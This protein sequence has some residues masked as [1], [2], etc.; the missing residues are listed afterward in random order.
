MSFTNHQHGS[1]SR[2]ILLALGSAALAAWT[3]HASS[4]NVTYYR[5]VAPILQA[6]CVGCHKPAGK[7]IGS[8]VAPMSLM[9]YEDV[10]PWARGIARK[11]ATREMPPWFADGPK[12]VFANERGLTDEQVAT[13]VAWADAGAPAGEGNQ[14]PAPIADAESGSGGY[15]LGRPDLIVRMPEPALVGDNVRDLQ[16]VLHVPVSAEMLPRDVYVRAWEFRAGTYLA[17]RD[18]VHHMC[19]VI[20][21]PTVTGERLD[22]VATEGVAAAG[23]FSLGCI[24]GGAEAAELPDGFGMELKKGSTITF[25][26]HYYKKPGPGTGYLNQAEV[27]FYFA[28]KP[29]THH[30]QV[31][32]IGTEGFE[33]PPQDANHRVGAGDVLQKDIVALSYW[34]H[35]H[36]RLAQAKYTAT[37]PDGRSEVLLNVP[38]YDQGWQVTYILKQPKFLPKGT[39]IDVEMFYDNSPTRAR[40]KGFNPDAV[41]RDGPRTQD[42]MM[43]GFLTYAEL[44]PGQDRFRDR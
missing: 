35:G 33:I 37:Y 29:I 16:A 44:E 6:N 1:W 20:Q 24:A 39:R 43:L 41:V 17:G 23:G 15:S 11:V 14:A 32:A 31:K 40:V 22:E 38:R 18:T 27:G 3:G 34:P 10:R 25:D 13:L 9:T 26:I 36:L 28:R 5:D 12:G 7:N 42:E 21:P 30:V 2:P 4:A 19:G 8:L